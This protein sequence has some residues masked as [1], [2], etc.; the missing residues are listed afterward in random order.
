VTAPGGEASSGAVAVTRLTLTEFRC[1]AR[2]RLEV[3]PGAVVLTG[4]NGAGKTNILEA[5][6]LLV[7]GRGLRSAKLSDLTRHEAGAGS[8]WAVAATARSAEGPVHLGTGL[9]V[10][11]G[12]VT[13]RRLVRVNGEA[14][15]SQ[16]ALGAHLSALWLVPAMDGLF[17]DGAGERRRFL[18]RMVQALD[19]D[20]AGRCAAHAHALR[21][22]NRLLREGR[23]G[24]IG[25]REGA[26]LDALEDTLARHGV[27]IA[28]AR[29]DLV[30]RLSGA[31]AQAEGPF[32]GAVLA[33]D[34]AVEAALADQPALAIEDDLRAALARDRAEDAQAGGT[35]H[36]P[37]RSD[38]LVRH[39]GRDRPAAQC[40]T[41]EQKAVLI[42]LIL[43]QARVVAAAR[44]G[45]PLLLLDE[46]VAHLDEARRAA[47]AEALAAL[48]AQA[49]LTGTDTALFDAFAAKAQFLRLEDGN[50]IE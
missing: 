5:L 16:T 1:Y 41:G 32:P 7:P 12:A 31:L 14:A 21:E 24:L 49:W 34:G 48:G 46:V 45:A 43:A 42:A 15:R 9:D 6:S 22:R 4:P 29:R 37:H 39:A 8:G 19:P 20:H 47:L 50:L 2:L 17:R 36:G 13:D 33:L 3:G 10:S 30:A 26:W 27:A 44:G 28:A 25:R 35:R 38:L 40:S 11:T 23:G 18:D